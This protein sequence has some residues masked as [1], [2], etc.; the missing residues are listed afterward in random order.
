MQGIWMLWD[1][2]VP[3]RMC[4]ELKKKKKKCK[5]NSSMSKKLGRDKL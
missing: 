1:K 2:T 3:D 4:S 5:G